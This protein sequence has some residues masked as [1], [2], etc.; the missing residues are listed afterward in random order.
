M[1][2]SSKTLGWL[3]P[4]IMFG[5]ILMMWNV[6]TPIVTDEYCFYKLSLNFPDYHGT[7]DWFLKD[8]PSM[9][10]NSINWNKEEQAQAF[11]TIY[12][13]QL[14]PHVPLMPMIFSPLVKGLNYLADRNVIP[15][16]ESEAG[17]DAPLES[18]KAETITIILRTLSIITLLVSMYLIFRLLYEK[19]GKIAYF[20]PV[21]LA[22]SYQL[23]FGAFLFYWDVFMIFFFVLTLY[24]MERK[25]KWAYLTACLM[26]NTKMFV[27]LVFLIPLMF[28]N[29]KM[30]FAGLAIAPW[31]LVSW[32]VT[33]N[34]FYF[35]AHYFGVVDEHNYIAQLY[36][37]KDWL[38]ILIGL[39]MPFFVIMTF[40]IFRWIKKYPEYV[41]LLIICLIYA[42]NGGLALTHMSS[43]L[44]AGCLVFPIVAY[45]FKLDEKL[46][47]WIGSKKVKE[48]M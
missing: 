48:A 44:Y 43:L 30:V 23:L 39:G 22:A 46:S 3:L 40:P 11:H 24:L 1:K 29:W 41:A 9:L 10:N 31:F 17:L 7:A 5:I 28:K 34:L 21:P 15:H 42:Y 18:Q 32:V 12:D 35:F 36:N 37:F 19:I 14:Y 26:V 25:S 33:G 2:L 6:K 4:I 27:A 45:E 38:L 13:S 8:R 47:R 16:L 20:F